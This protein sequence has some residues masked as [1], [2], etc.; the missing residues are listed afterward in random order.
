MRNWIVF[1]AITTLV[2]FA[3]AGKA[4]AQRGLMVYLPFDDGRGDTTKDDSP[5]GNDGQ[6]VGGPKWVNG[7]FNGALEFDGEDDY[8]VIEK[9]NSLKFDSGDFTVEGWVNLS[10]NKLTGTPG[11]RFANNRGTGAGGTLHGW[12]IKIINEGGGGKWGFMDSGIDDASG[13]YKVHNPGFKVTTAPYDN[14]VWYHVGVVY[15]AGT[16]LSF[17]V[18]GELD[19]EVEVKNYGSLDNDLPVVIGAAIAHDGIREARLSQYFPGMI[20]D[21]RL[22]SRALSPEELKAN[23][24]GFAVEPAGKL[25]TIWGEIKVDH[26]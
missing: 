20:D 2:G 15:T 1:L 24:E 10:K 8:V 22:W 16:G 21:V 13:D 9:S 4:E 17:Y 18:N 25:A 5:N 6:L 14:G 11:G 26:R 3:F 7:K 12:Q 23:M 19:G